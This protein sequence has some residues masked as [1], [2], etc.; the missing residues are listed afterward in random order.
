MHFLSRLPPFL[1]ASIGILLLTGMDGLVKNL[2]AGYPTFQIVFMRFAFTALFIGIVML[3]LR[4][5]WPSRDRSKAHLGRAILM[6][7]A[8]SSFFYALGRLPLAEVFAISLT[9]PIFV[10]VFAA[11]FLK[12][13]VGLRVMLAIGSGFLGMLVIVFAGGPGTGAFGHPPLALAC[14]LLSPVIYALGIVLLR[15]QTM[16]EPIAAIVTAQ[17][18]FV[19]LL[20]SPVVAVQFV[21]PTPAHWAQFVGIGLLGSAGYL[22]FATGLKGLS[23]A[24]FSV[25]EYTGLIWAALFGYAFFGEVPRLAVWLG[26]LLIIAGCLIV[27]SEKVSK[28]APPPDQASGAA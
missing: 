19:A 26:A 6:V 5:R 27:I 20:L 16:Q 28:A 10:A 7:L 11:V 15:A 12:E 22:A 18:L 2:S 23:A 14:A 1:L 25:V 21:A 3:G 8:A 9:S 4:Q 17:S 24:R 13:P